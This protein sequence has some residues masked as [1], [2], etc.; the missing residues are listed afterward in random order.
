MRQLLCLLI[1]LS[2][3]M[4][5]L[6]AQKKPKRAKNIILLIADAG[7][8]PTLNAA[9]IYGYNAPLKLFIQSWQNMGLS[10]TTPAGRWV[11]DSA[12]GMTAIVT[13]QKTFNGVISQAPD[14]ERGKRDGTELKTILE[15]AEEKGLATGV[16]SNMA[17]TDATPAACYSH[18][19]DR[20]NWG[21]IFLE[22]FTPKYGDG[23]DL[24]IGGGRKRIYEEAVKIGKNI[25]EVAAVKKRPVMSDLGELKEGET[26]GLVVMDQ[27]FP[28]EEAAR[29]ALAGLSK[30]K[31][32]YFLMI[33]WDA[34]TNNPKTGLSR[35]VEFDKVIK[36]I[37]SQ[38]NLDET[39]LIF[40]ADHSFDFR[41]VSGG[42]DSEILKGLDQWKAD[43]ANPRSMRLSHIRMEN[44]HTGEEVL[45]AAMGAGAERVRGFMPNTEIFHIM[46]AAY[47]WPEST[48]IVSQKSTAAGNQKGN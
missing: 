5:V 44:T 16:V 32:G 23:V 14:G 4:P 38:V 27:P 3:S 19:N 10:D 7:G 45:V 48:K 31:K 1:A 35:V 43:P 37:A 47:G 13:G 26:R 34:H 42:P 22:L 24:L 15:Y 39:L 28:L 25:D 9:S 12:A 11:S 33:E 6:P 41:V 46:M 17:I 29:K 36:Q 18:S 20:A 30:N 40:T 2:V 8:I 21:E